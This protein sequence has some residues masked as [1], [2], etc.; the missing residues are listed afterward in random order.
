MSETNKAFSMGIDA[1]LKNS[2]REPE[3]KQESKAPSHGIATIQSTTAYHLFKTINSNRVVDRSHVAKLIKAIRKKNLLHL[4]PI[5]VDKDMNVIDGQHRLQAAKI[6][7]VPVYY[8]RDCKVSEEDM[9]DMNSIKKNWTL[10]DY[11]HYYISRGKHDFIEF[12]KVMERHPNVPVST[13]LKV[14]SGNSSTRSSDIR[15]GEIDTDNIEKADEIIKQ[16]NDINE[17]CPSIAGSRLTEAMIYFA[18]HPDYDHKRMVKRI[19]TNPSEIHAC[20]NKKQYIQML[21]SVY[22]FR[23]K[24]DNVVI[25]IKR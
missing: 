12:S 5:T 18:N 4:Q 20:N 24:E 23:A 19:Q 2:K 21:Q 11:L 10:N 17:L 16:L 15:N 22:N 1:Y 3:Q 14:V 25:F 9:S 6:L 7:Q 8:Q 13:L